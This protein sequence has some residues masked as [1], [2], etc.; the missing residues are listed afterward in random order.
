M[1]LDK[2]LTFSEHLQRAKTT[3]ISRIL[4]LYSFLSNSVRYPKTGIMLY[5]LHI[6]PIFTYASPSRVM[7]APSHI[8]S[9]VRAQNRSLQIVP[10][11][12][13]RS[14]L[15]ALKAR[16]D[17]KPSTEDRYHAEDMWTN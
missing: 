13:H 10:H 11:L 9:P 6:R 4:Q 8:Q 14:A 2:R 3:A 5:T 7:T 17:G 12:P 16:S 15:V 1:I